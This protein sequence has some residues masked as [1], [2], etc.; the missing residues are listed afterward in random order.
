MNL[1]EDDD[2][3]GIFGNDGSFND[4]LFLQSIKSKYMRDKDSGQNVIK[5]MKNKSKN[6]H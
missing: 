4:A 3:D 1:E 2:S 5:A 6:F